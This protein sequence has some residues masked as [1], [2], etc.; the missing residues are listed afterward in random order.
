[1]F[2]HRLCYNNVLALILV[3]VRFTIKFKLPLNWRTVADHADTLK[4]VYEIR[5]FKGALVASS[6]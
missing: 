2:L 5:G 4:L 1:M 3:I 6:R